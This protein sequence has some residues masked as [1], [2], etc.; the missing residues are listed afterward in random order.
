MSHGKTYTFQRQDLE[1]TVISVIRGQGKSGIF[2][3]KTCIHPVV[4]DESRV[5]NHLLYKRGILCRKYLRDILE[6]NVFIQCPVSEVG[7]HLK[8][9]FCHSILIFPFQCRFNPLELDF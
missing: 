2:F 5:A 6:I 3:P 8:A 9:S 1:N 4:G 7:R